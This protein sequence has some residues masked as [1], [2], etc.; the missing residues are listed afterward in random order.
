[1]LDCVKVDP[2]GKIKLDHIPNLAMLG[3]YHAMTT[4]FSSDTSTQPVS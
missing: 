2:D 3:A 4:Y 1:M